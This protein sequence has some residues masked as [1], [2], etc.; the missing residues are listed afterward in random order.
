MQHVFERLAARDAVLPNDE[1]LSDYLCAEAAGRVQTVNLHH[2]YLVARD[3]SFCCATLA[4]DRYTADGWPI[5][6]ICQLLGHQ[7]ARVTGRA[8]VQNLVERRPKSHRVALVG[9]T[10]TSGDAFAELLKSAGHVLV[11]QEHGRVEDWDAENLALKIQVAHADVV[12]VA[13]T[14][15]R[16]EEVA[17]RI[18]VRLPGKSI[19][20]VGGAI[21]MAVGAARPAPPA[22]RLA[23]A[24][25]L[26]R[27][28]GDPRRLWRRYL[29]ECLPTLLI[30]VPSALI[31]HRLRNP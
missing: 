2:V 18:Q 10:Q 1:S 15:P 20:A 28:L 16:G 24:E 12:L 25:W 22:W 11:L 31:R 5:V 13:V 3:P 26:W 21:D 17:A 30:T 29:L 7:V 27:L 9:A 4:A 6:L 19:I 8:Y 14:P 23:G